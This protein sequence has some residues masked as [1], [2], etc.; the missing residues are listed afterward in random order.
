MAV[1]RQSTALRNAQATA[2]GTALDAGPAAG[3]IQ[4][5]SGTIPATPATAVTGTLLATVTLADPSAGA[6]AN[7]VLTITDP[8]AV[9]GVGDGTAT[10]ARFFDSTGAVVLDCD[11]TATGGGGALTLS[12]TTISTGLTIDLGAVTYTA[13]A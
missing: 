2:V 11:V 6:P 1:L 5:R 12:T 3:Y 10:W 4:L 9:T 7:G 13:P 8:A